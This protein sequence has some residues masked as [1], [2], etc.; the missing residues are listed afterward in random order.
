GSDAVVLTSRLSVKSHPWLADHVVVGSV[1]VPGT[2]LVELAVQAGDRVGCDRVEE[3]TLQAPLVLPQDGAVDIQIS[4]D[5]S[6]SGEGRREVRVYSRGEDAGTDEPWTLHATG[7]LTATAERG[8]VDWDLRAWPPAGAESVSLE[9]LYER[10][11]GVG[12]AYGPAFRGL[13][14]V[15][16]QGEDLF[17]EAVLPEHVA[18]EA[19]GFGLHPALLDS[20]LHAL[21]LRGES[22]EGVLLPFLWSGVSLSAVGASAVRVRL[23]PR[24]TGEIGLRV[25]DATGD[26]VAEIDSLV[27]RPVQ[28][29]ELAV[30][31]RSHAD[32]LFR[33]EWTPAPPSTGSDE[34]VQ[35]GAWVALGGPGEWREAGIP[36]TTYADLSGLIAALDGGA[37]TPETVLL[38]VPV[39]DV[40]G[41]D[42]GTTDVVASVL[43]VVRGWLGES[44]FVS[45]R[46][47]VVTCGAMGVSEGDGVDLGGAG[48]WGLV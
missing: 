44:R 17:V 41:V 38:P 10:L 48:V 34:T 35:D 23:T 9:G 33:L 3:L 27:L 42:S 7:V 6:E 24:G 4:V 36:V 2:A 40:A 46:L 28:A 8:A 31:N 25:A 45:S 43:E 21:G 37:D 12:L 39:P 14:G 32:S 13:R 11:A 19:S 1:L 22:V 16:K 26:P 18:D 30:A 29:A 47:V 5:A 15:W 20:V